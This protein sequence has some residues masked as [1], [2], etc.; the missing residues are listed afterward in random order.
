MYSFNGKN[1]RRKFEDL[2]LC[3]NVPNQLP[4]RPLVFYYIDRLKNVLSTIDVQLIKSRGGDIFEV[5]DEQ[6]KQQVAQLW[7]NMKK[8]IPIQTVINDSF[9][10]KEIQKLTVYDSRES[11]ILDMWDIYDKFKHEFLTYFGINNTETEKKERMITDEVNANNELIAHGF[12]ESQYLCRLDFCSRCNEHF[13]WNIL[14]LKNRCEDSDEGEKIVEETIGENTEIEEVIEEIR[15]NT[16]SEKEVV[17][18]VDNE[19]N[20]DTTD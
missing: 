4:T 19:Q 18:D 17:E 3:E 12:Y 6:Q 2:E 10:K 5:G 1:W 15:E 13:G 16:E 8:N 7:D 14:C 9:S 11:Q 20:N